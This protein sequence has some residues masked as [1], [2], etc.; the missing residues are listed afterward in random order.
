MTETTLAW[1]P[2]TK[3]TENVGG[4]SDGTGHGTSA[5]LGLRS[6]E[7]VCLSFEGVCLNSRHPGARRV[8]KGGVR[9]GAD[10]TRN[11]SV[12]DAASAPG[13]ADVF[14][15]VQIYCFLQATRRRSGVMFFVLTFSWTSH[16]KHL[17]LRVLLEDLLPEMLS[18]L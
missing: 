17:L 16:L 8:W 13:A 6:A 2:Q 10:D 12:P 11:G 1:A 15:N 3:S 9:A 5:A 14:Q 18:K 7:Y 4:A